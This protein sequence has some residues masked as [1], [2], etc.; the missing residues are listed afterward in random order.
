[1]ADDNSQTLIETIEPSLMVKG[2]RELL[3]QLFANLIENALRHSPRGSTVRVIAA[4]FEDR[5]RVSI[6]DNGRGIP[7]EERSK[8]LQRFY[9][10]E[11]SRTTVGN[12][13]GLSLANA[14]AELHDTTL[15]LSDADP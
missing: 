15:E 11:A 7:R 14:I 5:V 13:L 9:R 2:E 4:R 10:L 3:M 6:V 1:M 12:G 8:V